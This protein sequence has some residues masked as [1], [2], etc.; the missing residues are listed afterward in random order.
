MIPNELAGDGKRS[1]QGG[2]ALAEMLR[3]H[4]A[5][6]MFG[7][8]GFQLLPMYDAFADLKLTHYLIN[9][10]RAG[11]WAADAYARMTGRPGICD[12]TLG[13][14][15]TNLVTAL[16][17]SLNAGVPI[18][19]IVG[20]A[21]RA[22]S[23]KNMTQECRQADILRPCVKELIRVEDARRIPELVRRAFWTATVGRPGPVVLDVPEDI[24]HEWVSFD[25]SEFTAAPGF[26]ATPGLRIRPDQRAVR[27]AGQL[28]RKATRPLLLAGGG[29][30]LSR[31]Y[32]SL[33]R[34]AETLGIPVAHT[35]SGKG[36]IP[37]IDP[38]S[39]G[40]FGR[41]SRTANDL[42]GLSDCL[43]VVGSKLGEIATRRYELLPPDVPVIQ[44]D[45][46]AEEI[47]RT[48]HIDLGI[49]CDAES[50][51]TD[52]LEELASDASSIRARHADLLSEVHERR[53][54]WQQ[55]ATPRLESSVQPITMARLVTELNRVLPP[56][57][58]LIADGGFAAHWSGLLY[59]TK[60]AGRTF[61]AD[62]GLASIGYG[63][64]AAIGVALAEPDG[65]V[66]A[67]TGDGG[68]NMSIGELETALRLALGITVVVVNNAA[69]G[70]VKALQHT[71]F[72]GRYESADLHELNYASIANAYGCNGIRVEDPA[73]LGAALTAA[74]A[75]KIVPTV[76]DVVVTRDPSQML[77][78][79]DSRVI[80]AKA[81]DRIA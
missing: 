54:R 80:K 34:F 2:R 55:D 60:K 62:R 22:H 32:D 26:R 23:G 42:I 52:L 43:V 28:L 1:V 75:S 24:A 19:V 21:T 15:A 10:E 31:A 36:A 13:P 64:P 33:Q 76:I 65:P 69:S 61:V 66:V 18:I 46:D 63:L 45:I 67:L 68:F 35:L 47:G 56:D 37:C 70:Y 40:V 30:H 59:D 9:D 81:G 29:V 27:S 50:G 77:P 11:A 3:A 79:V 51:L 57:A 74:I 71:M 49:W 5:G 58:V 17:E 41:Y 6:P 48:S 8:G 53:L 25:G 44:M 7:M 73:E 12:A 4:D 39:V 38:L 14:G 20:D 72:A 16:V 78:G